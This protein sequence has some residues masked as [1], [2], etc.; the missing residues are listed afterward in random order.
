MTPQAEWDFLTPE[1][2][3]RWAWLAGIIDGEGAIQIITGVPSEPRRW[4]LD[5]AIGMCHRQT[6]QEIKR[7]THV[8]K[9]YERPPAPSRKQPHYVWTAHQK[10]AAAVLRTCLPM[11]VTKKAE[12]EL[13]LRFM[14]LVS[15]QGHGGQLLSFAQIDRR[16]ALRE[17]QKTLHL[18]GKPPP[19][20]KPPS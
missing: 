9:I 6:V 1:E 15:L 3:L 7:I 8:G 19:R 12:A 16:K 4:R 18:K 13:A 2:K 10:H 17:A 14:D 5:L 11:L 20:Q